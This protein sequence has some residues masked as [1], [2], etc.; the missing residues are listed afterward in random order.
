MEANLAEIL[1]GRKVGFCTVR[2]HSKVR[3]NPQRKKGSLMGTANFSLDLI[4]VLS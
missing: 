4:S 1:C 2:Y 3:A